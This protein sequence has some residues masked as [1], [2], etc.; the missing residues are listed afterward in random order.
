MTRLLYGEFSYD[1]KRN[2]EIDDEGTRV[3]L[4]LIEYDDDVDE[5]DVKN[6]RQI[7]ID[8][9]QAPLI[10]G[11]IESCIKFKNIVPNIAPSHKIDKKNIRR[12]SFAK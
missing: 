12:I 6:V 5:S 3:D 2:V 8:T 1:C 11:M 4:F 9:H 7:E 10:E